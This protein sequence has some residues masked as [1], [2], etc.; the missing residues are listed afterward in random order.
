MNQ[1]GIA[2]IDPEE[3]S[4]VRKLLRLLRHTDPVVAQLAREALRY[5]EDVEQRESGAAEKA[6]W[7]QRLHRVN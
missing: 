3:L 1:I 4:C 2:G 6:D 7:I 5:L